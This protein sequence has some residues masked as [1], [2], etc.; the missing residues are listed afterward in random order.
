MAKRKRYTVQEMRAMA[1][2]NQNDFDMVAKWKGSQSDVVEQNI[3][4]LVCGAPNI[5][6]IH[7][8]NMV[9]VMGAKYLC[10]D[11][12]GFGWA[13]MGNLCAEDP[14]EARQRGTVIEEGR[15]ISTLEENAKAG[16]DRLEANGMLFGSRKKIQSSNQNP[17]AAY[18]PIR[19]FDDDTLLLHLSKCKHPRDIDEGKSWELWIEKKSK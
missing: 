12:T 8:H 16:G 18:K 10:E 11:C 14:E 19:N 6:I 7:R 1:A 13:W 9:N 2:Q 15:S 5:M 17:T 4:C 3:N